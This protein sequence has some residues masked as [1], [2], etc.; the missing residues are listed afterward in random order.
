MISTH[1][2]KFNINRPGMKV[3]TPNI[4]KEKSEASPCFFEMTNDTTSI[5]R[6]LTR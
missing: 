6:L 4:H 3:Q 2:M 1:I 5:T